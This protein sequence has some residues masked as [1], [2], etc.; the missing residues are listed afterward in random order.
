AGADL[1]RSI[2]TRVV[3]EFAPGPSRMIVASLSIRQVPPCGICFK[4][5]ITYLP[6]SLRSVTVIVR[7]IKANSSTG[8]VACALTG[9]AQQ[10]NGITPRAPQRILYITCTPLDRRR[11]IAWH[12]RRLGP[13]VPAIYSSAVK[14]QRR[15]ARCRQ[16]R[17]EVYWDAA[18]TMTLDV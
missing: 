8:S 5:T 13:P 12:V 3:S 2:A 1:S 11:R 7:G 16:P 4:S 9:N 10:I 17:G 15:R 6:P 18:R 14:R